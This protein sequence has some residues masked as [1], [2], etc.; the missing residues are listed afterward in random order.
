MQPNLF[1]YLKLMGNPMLTMAL[2]VLIIGLIQ[3]VMELLVYLLSPFNGFGSLLR[4][5]LSMG[6]FLM[7]G[8][9]G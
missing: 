1:A 8:C 4:L 7:C 3:N 6:I 5:R 2:L 9:K